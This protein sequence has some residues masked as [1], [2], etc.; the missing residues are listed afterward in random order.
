MKYKK[1]EKDNPTSLETIECNVCNGDGFWYICREVDG[2]VVSKKIICT[3]CLGHGDLVTIPIAEE[4]K[5][6][7]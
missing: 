6:S 3:E 7:N 2:K 4:N 1:L 5:T